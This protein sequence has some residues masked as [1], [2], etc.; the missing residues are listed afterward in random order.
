MPKEKGFESKYQSPEN[1][2]EEQQEK[3]RRAKIPK[4]LDELDALKASQELAREEGISLEGEGDPTRL[5]Q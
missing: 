1:Q 2:R 3:E 4:E 5:D